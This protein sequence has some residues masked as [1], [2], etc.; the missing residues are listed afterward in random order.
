MVSDL[1]LH[2]VNT[3]G[4][5]SD[6][7]VFERVVSAV[8]SFFRGSKARAFTAQPGIVTRAQWGAN[9]S[10]RA[11]C[12]RYA[13]AVKMAFVH[14][15]A[16]Q[17]S[18]SRSES[19][20]L[21]RSVYAFHV[22]NRG[23]DD[24]GYNFLVDRYGQVFEGRA[25]GMTE[26]VIGAHV[27]GFNTGSTGISLMGTFSTVSP[28]SAMIGAL[29]NLVAWKLDVH[30]VPP[31]GKVVMTSG[32]APLYPYGTK[33]TFNRISGHQRRP[34]DL[35]PGRARLQQ[36]PR[37]PDGGLQDRA[38]EAVPPALELDDPAPRR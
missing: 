6:P 10:I 37:D 33:R 2:L 18:Y 28:T 27:K 38:A 11:C 29:K 5:A 23:W 4:D 34:A 21:V 7:N 25:G 13:P 16:G 20:A 1:R 12:P 31:I 35:V 8:S 15:T 30:N 9:E 26:P 14:H 19:Y 36:A 24:I 22:K 32:G 3:L 17:N